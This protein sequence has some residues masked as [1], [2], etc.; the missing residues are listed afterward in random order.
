MDKW[1]AAERAIYDAQMIIEAGPAHPLLTEAGTLLSQAQEKVADYID[2]HD[3][4]VRFNAPPKTPEIEVLASALRKY[5]PDL[6]DELA[7]RWTDSQ[8]ALQ[9]FVA[10]LQENK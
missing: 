10:F 5:A 3:P 6:A 1:S 4:A 7:K 9:R 2:H 8:R